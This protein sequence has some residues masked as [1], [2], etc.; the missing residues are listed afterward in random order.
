VVQINIGQTKEIQWSLR[1]SALFVSEKS[2]RS[3]VKRPERGVSCSG[4]VVKRGLECRDGPRYDGT[5]WTK[6]DPEA[7]HAVD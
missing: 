3:E 6:R 4:P 2:F 7:P 1:C 5:Q